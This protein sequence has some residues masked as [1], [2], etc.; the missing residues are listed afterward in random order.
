MQ[1]ARND[2]LTLTQSG[3]QPPAFQSLSLFLV[4]LLVPF[5]QNC[6]VWGVWKS[7]VASTRVN[8]FIFAL[9]YLIIVLFNHD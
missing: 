1:G 5:V 3:P 9:S 7:L 2:R 4:G 8:R 6:Q